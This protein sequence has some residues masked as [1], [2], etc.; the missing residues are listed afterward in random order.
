MRLKDLALTQ[1]EL[2]TLLQNGVIPINELRDALGLEPINGG[3]EATILTNT[4]PFAVS[5]LPSA[6]RYAE[7][8]VR[9]DRLPRR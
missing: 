8:L 3:D 5:N 2:I 6:V 9:E 1:A 4:G 7:R